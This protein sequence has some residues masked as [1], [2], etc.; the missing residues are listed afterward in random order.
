M[1]L[2]YTHRTMTMLSY[3][4]LVYSYCTTSSYITI[5]VQVRRFLV[6]ISYP[7]VYKAMILQ[8][9]QLMLTPIIRTS[10]LDTAPYFGKR[11]FSPKANCDA[12]MTTG[13]LATCQFGNRHHQRGMKRASLITYRSSELRRDWSRGTVA[14]G[15]GKNVLVTTDLK[16]IVTQ[17]MIASLVL[18]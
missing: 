10:T 7:Y 1:I 15:N 9:R 14:T 12:E 2:E 17:S 6:D 4:L 3:V 5:T 13:Q 8:P 11:L 18:V 16:V